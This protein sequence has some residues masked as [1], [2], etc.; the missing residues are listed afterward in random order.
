MTAGR[1]PGGTS[2]GVAPPAR[3]TPRPAHGLLL[4]ALMLGAWAPVLL[5]IHFLPRILP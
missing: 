1:K 5:A 4:L 2:F 3:S